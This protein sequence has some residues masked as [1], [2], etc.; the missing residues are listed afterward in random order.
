MVRANSRYELAP[1]AVISI[2]PGPF[3]QVAPW[4]VGSGRKAAAVIAAPQPT[5][6]EK[7]GKLVPL[8]TAG[9]SSVGDRLGSVLYPNGAAWVML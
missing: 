8:K 5:F 1:E 6:V 7:I 2:R 3:V 4:I 9:F